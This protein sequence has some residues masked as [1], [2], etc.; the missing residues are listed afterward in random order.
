MQQDLDESVKFKR[1]MKRAFIVL[2]LIEFVVTVYGVFY[3][4]HK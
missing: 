4:I 2:A 3:V 1:Q